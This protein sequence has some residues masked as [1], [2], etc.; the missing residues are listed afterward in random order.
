MHRFPCEMSHVPSEQ[1]ELMAAYLQLR[2]ERQA[3]ATRTRTRRVLDEASA[4]E[5]DLTAAIAEAEQQLAG[6]RTGLR[7]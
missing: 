2:K 5:N 6:M 7:R 3:A 1:L 4:A